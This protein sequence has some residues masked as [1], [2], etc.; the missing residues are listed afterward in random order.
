MTATD[1]P[2]AGRLLVAT[3]QLV[4][5]N[6]SRAVVLLCG[7]DSD[8]ALGLVLDRP[9]SEPAA[10]H[11]PAWAGRLA[12]P[13]MVFVG[14]PVQPETA[15]GLVIT[16]PEWEHE[17]L[18]PISDGL[19]LFDLTSGP[20]DGIVAARVFSGYAGW[21]PGQLQAEVD[22]GDWFV[23]ETDPADPLT[24]DPT[25]LRSRVLRRQGPP[26]ALYASMPPDAALN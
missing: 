24:T 25:G 20:A 17:A 23:V 18:S 19:A 12:T 10:R 13:G 15:V 2:P 14:G 16:A 7:H 11:L 26:L 1:P 9:T 4:D 6:F 8:G 22:G 21:G 5:P 3:P